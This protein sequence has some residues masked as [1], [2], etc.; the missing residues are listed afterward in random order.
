VA[1]YSVRNIYINHFQGSN[2]RL[3]V[4]SELDQ[5]ILLVKMVPPRDFLP[6]AEDQQE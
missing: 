4:W 2:G 3:T 6:G 1:R 5:A